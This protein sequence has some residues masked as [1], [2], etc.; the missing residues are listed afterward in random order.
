MPL[1]L[2]DELTLLKDSTNSP[3]VCLG[4]A[5]QLTLSRELDLWRISSQPVALVVP[6]ELCAR[7]L[8][9]VPTISKNANFLPWF[10]NA[11]ACLGKL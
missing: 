11:F 6:Y 5:P 8:K 10:R 7:A 9:L 4:G 2:A 1:R 3:T